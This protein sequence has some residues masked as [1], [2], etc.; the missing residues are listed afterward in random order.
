MLMPD[1]DGY[2]AVLNRAHPNT[3]QAFS[4]AHEIGHLLLLAQG[5]AEPKFRSRLGSCTGTA[6][7]PIERI[8]DV[9][10]SEML[11]PEEPFASVVGKSGW[12]LSSVSKLKAAFG[13]S[14]EATARR[15]VNLAPEPRALLKWG[16]DKRKWPQYQQ[17][18]IL[19]A[20]WTIGAVW[21]DQ[22]RHLFEMPSLCQAYTQNGPTQGK[23]EFVVVSEPSQRVALHCESLGLGTG[24]SRA[25][26]TM[27]YADR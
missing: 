26:Y 18:P 11:M 2:I 8:C 20:Y 5:D 10:A 22:R 16:L 14:Y 3:R 7:D 24:Q 6:Q 25:V 27:L 21:F 15:L 4:L 13:T 9:L 19:N 1:A 12:R 23:E 17:R